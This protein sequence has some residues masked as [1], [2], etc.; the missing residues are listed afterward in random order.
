MEIEDYTQYDHNPNPQ[1]LR[2]YLHR[3]GLITVRRNDLQVCDILQMKYDYE[4]GK[5]LAMVT[6]IGM[7][8]AAAN[9]KMVV[10]HV[11]D[12]VLMSR[13]VSIWRWPWLH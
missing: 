9:R 1:V 8:H 12:S 6:D 10:E 7:I 13:V 11:I 4:D 3:N 2:E 5:H